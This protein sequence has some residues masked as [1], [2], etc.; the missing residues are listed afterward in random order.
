MERKKAEYTYIP[1]HEGDVHK[2]RAPVHSS[3]KIEETT[4]RQRNMELVGKVGIKD[5]T[6]HKLPASGENVRINTGDKQ[7]SDDQDPAKSA[8]EQR[9]VVNAD[10]NAQRVQRTPGPICDGQ[11]GTKAVGTNTKNVVQVER[12][13]AETEGDFD[14]GSFLASLIQKLRFQISF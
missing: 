8:T 2:T 12:L 4:S 6:E 11:D 9:D 5:A 1:S 7:T 3:M 14:V 13:T 10:T